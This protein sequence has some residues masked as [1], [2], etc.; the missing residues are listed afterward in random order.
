MCSET[1]LVVRRIEVKHGGLNV[2]RITSKM[3]WWQSMDFGLN[4]WATMIHTRP[5]FFDVCG[6]DI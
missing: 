6:A 5:E 3:W 2:V 4:P 1:G